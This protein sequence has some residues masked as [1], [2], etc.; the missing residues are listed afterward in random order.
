MFAR[1]NTSAFRE[2]RTFPIIRKLPHGSILELF[3]QLVKGKHNLRQCT[4]LH[5]GSVVWHSSRS[6]PKMRAMT[7]IKCWVIF[8]SRCDLRGECLSAKARKMSILKG[9]Q[10]SLRFG[11]H[12]NEVW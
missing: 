2:N 8:F 1:G 6:F 10:L 5:C 9:L 12:T 3:Y 4:V 7:T 11:T